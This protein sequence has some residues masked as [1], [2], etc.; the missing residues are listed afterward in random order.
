MNRQEIGKLGEKIAQNHLKKNGYRIK[1][2]NYRS[3]EGEVDI[4]C[5]KKNFLVFVEVRTKTGSDFGI[6]E[7]SITSS[8][9][10]KLVNCALSYLN[11]Q[12]KADELWRIDFIGVD[13]Q[14]DGKPGRV[15]H[16]ENAVAY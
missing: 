16:I 2:V 8:K 5:K 3:K 12:K 14:E 4:I 6:P 9:K 11:E 15:V 13:L 7:E 10:S 1:E